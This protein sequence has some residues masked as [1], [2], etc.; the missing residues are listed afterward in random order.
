MII[1]EK[2]N[3]FLRIK[4]SDDSLVNS[5]PRSRGVL[6]K[7]ILGDYILEF[8]FRNTR[9]TDSIIGGFCFLGPIKSKDFFYTVMFSNDTIRFLTIMNDSIHA[10]VKKTTMSLN[11]SWNKVRIERNILT[12]TL[13]FI[14]NGDKQNVI[15]FSDRNLVMGYVGFGTQLTT[16]YIRNIRLWAPT[17]IDED[18]F[19]WQIVD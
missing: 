1:R 19:Q 12:R 5:F 16:S 10:C 17:A 6:N 2:G 8:E 11:S 15:N 14:I 13:S 18:E 3:N 9:L 7:L 4:S